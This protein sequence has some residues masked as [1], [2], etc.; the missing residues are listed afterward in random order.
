M[1]EDSKSMREIMQAYTKALAGYLNQQAGVWQTFQPAKVLLPVYE[2]IPKKRR[3]QV[4]VAI[5]MAGF[6]EA[7]KAYGREITRAVYYCDSALNDVR[8]SDAA[9]GIWQMA[10]PTIGGQYYGYLTKNVKKPNVSRK[11]VSQ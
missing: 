11:E 5:R 1:I 2:K 3:V 9:T 4:A 7:S 10:Q 8:D 6:H